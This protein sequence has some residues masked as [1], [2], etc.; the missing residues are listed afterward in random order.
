M[1]ERRCRVN[2]HNER[3]KTDPGAD[4]DPPVEVITK[5]KDIALDHEQELEKDAKNA[6]RFIKQVW[7]WLDSDDKD[8]DNG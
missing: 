3:D 8:A 1:M 4:N 7:H 6:A 5:R 2:H